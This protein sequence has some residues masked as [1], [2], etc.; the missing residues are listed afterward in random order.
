M[1][2]AESFSKGRGGRSVLAG[3]VI[4]KDLVV[5]GFA[6]ANITVGGMDA[7]Q[8]VLELYKS[9]DRTDI[10][11]VMLSGCVVAWFNVVDLAKVHEELKLPLIC[12]TYEESEGLEK[13][14]KEYFPEDWEKRISIFSRNCLRKEAWLKTGYRV[15]VR[16]L[17]IDFEE[18]LAIL[19]GFTLQGGIPEPLR[20]ARL[21]ARTIHRAHDKGVITE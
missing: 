9:L 13:Y 7:T 20:L 2:L 15:F 12:V 5:D 14:F 11:L 6:V 8:G 17:G 19:N 18:A 4:R 10:N 16:E 1:G 21:L 3:V